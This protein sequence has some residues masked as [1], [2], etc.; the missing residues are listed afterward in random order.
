[1]NI[2]TTKQ[3]DTF[4]KIAY[5]IF[6]DHYLFGAIMEVNIELID[7]VI[8]PAGINVNIPNI[9]IKNHIMDSPPW[10]R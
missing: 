5:K 3:G 1:M 6:G 2:Y 9:D 4:D 10:K 7:Y 8:F